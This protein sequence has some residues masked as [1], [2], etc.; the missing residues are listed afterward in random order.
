MTDPTPLPVRI[1]PEF[2]YTARLSESRP[3]H[4]R[5][6]PSSWFVTFG[7]G[8][9]AQGTYAEV[10]FDLQ[11]DEEGE[12]LPEHV[13]DAV[14]RRVAVDLYGTA[15]AFHYRPDEYASAIE[16]WNLRLRERVVVSTVEVWT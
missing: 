12:E 2:D 15:W 16:R 6:D 5:P 8:K 9:P 7:F 11:V 14:V 3:M 4:E 13:L 1:A 10:A